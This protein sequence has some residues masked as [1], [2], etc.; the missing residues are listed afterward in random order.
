M[1]GKHPGIKSQSHGHVNKGVLE[2]TF[3]YRSCKGTPRNCL[4]CQT[5]VHIDEIR[6]EDWKQTF[7]RQMRGLFNDECSQRGTLWISLTPISKR[8]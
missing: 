3:Q 6:S 8:N 2:I 5:Y 7:C 4:S 1:E